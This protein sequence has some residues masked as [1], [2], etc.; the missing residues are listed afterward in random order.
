[1]YH[2][3]RRRNKIIHKYI[4]FMVVV[5]SMKYYYIRSV[6]LIDGTGT[7]DLCYFSDYVI[8]YGTLRV[9]VLYEYSTTVEYGVTPIVP[10]L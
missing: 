7:R 3:V 6:L 10:V 1:M 9:T 5:G 8:P 4:C 2:A